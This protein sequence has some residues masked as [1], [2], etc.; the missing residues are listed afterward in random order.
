MIASKKEGGKKKHHF[1]L[2]YFL[3]DRQMQT[4]CMK[5]FALAPFFAYDLNSGT[6]S[7]HYAVWSAYLLH[8]FLLFCTAE[9]TDLLSK[10]PCDGS[11]VSCFRFSLLCYKE[12]AIKSPLSR[13][14]CSSVPVCSYA[15]SLVVSFF[16]LT[17]KSSTLMIQ[18][19]H[20][21][22]WPIILHLS[23]GGRLIHWAK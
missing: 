18:H 4:S 17:W 6:A 14:F 20:F 21:S 7:K 5:V 16:L 19:A 15:L 22:R 1:I 23:L 9:Y 11:S 10:C 2:F 3:L 8:S 13:R 12:Y